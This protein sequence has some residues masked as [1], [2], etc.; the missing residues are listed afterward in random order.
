MTTISAPGHNFKCQVG[1]FRENSEARRSLSGTKIWPEKGLRQL[2]HRDLYFTG[3]DT[4]A[5]E[6]TDLGALPR[7]I[8]HWQGWQR[9]EGSHE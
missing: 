7:Q 3:E 6:E 9:G 5:Q 4:K 2:G 1:G 8:S